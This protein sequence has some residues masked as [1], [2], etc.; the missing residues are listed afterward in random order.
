MIKNLKLW[1]ALHGV[2]ANAVLEAIAL[3][4]VITSIATQLTG[5]ETASDIAFVVSFLAALF[6]LIK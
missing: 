5:F 3:A 1:I 2:D 4:S 6:R